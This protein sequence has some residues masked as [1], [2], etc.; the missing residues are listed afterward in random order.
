MTC[1]MCK[2][3]GKPDYLGSDPICY[4]DDPRGNWNCATVNEVR[5][6]VGGELGWGA[7]NLP[8][9][10]YVTQCDDEHYATLRLDE[11]DDLYNEEKETFP[12][13]LYVQWY[14]NRGRTEELWILG[15]KNGEPR[16]PTEAELL[17]IVA[18]YKNFCP[19]CLQYRPDDERVK[20]GLKCR[21]CAYGEEASK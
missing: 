8:R 2:E 18:Y 12:Y 9:G 16:R 15:E 21:F 5:G 17:A 13:C 4:F 11:I 20:A 6:I 1:K 14:K 19:E 3:R 10:V 7:Y